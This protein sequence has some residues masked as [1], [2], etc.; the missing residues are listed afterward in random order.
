MN[1]AMSSVMGN[2]VNDIVSGKI[3]TDK[4]NELSQ[5]FKNKQN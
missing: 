1:T 3:S 5:Q 2:I 4:I